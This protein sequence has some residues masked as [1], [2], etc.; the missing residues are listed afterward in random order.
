MPQAAIKLGVVMDPIGS[1]KPAKDT[2]LAM[3]LAAQ[4]RGWTLHYLEQPDLYLRDGEARG[5]TRQLNVRNTA[6][7]WFSFGEERDL[8]LG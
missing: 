3:L 5:R 7:D 4:A 8:G 2:T 6:Q 1:I